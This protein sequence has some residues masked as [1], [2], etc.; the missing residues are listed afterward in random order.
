MGPNDDDNVAEYVKSVSYMIIVY[1]H[2]S[3]QIHMYVC[4]KRSQSKLIHTYRSTIIYK[5][6][7]NIKMRHIRA[8]GTIKH[9]GAARRGVGRC[10]QR[11]TSSR[12]RQVPALYKYVIGI[13]YI[14]IMIVRVCVYT[15]GILSAKEENFSLCIITKCLTRRMSG[16]IKIYTRFFGLILF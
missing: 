7:L 13:R 9:R 1:I 8:Q 16:M 5:Q 11:N 12:A 4:I 2:T 14:I 10:V 3:I 6:K 15:R